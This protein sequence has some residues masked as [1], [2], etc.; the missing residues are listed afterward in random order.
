MPGFIKSSTGAIAEAAKKILLDLG[1]PQ[2]ATALLARV[3]DDTLPLVSRVHAMKTLGGL[4]KNAPANLTEM[5]RTFRKQK[6]LPP[7]LRAAALEVLMEKTPGE[8]VNLVRDTMVNGE[9][10]EKQKGMALLGKFKN[11]DAKK[12]T[13]EHG[14]MLVRDTLDPAVQVEIIEIAHQQDKKRGE[15]RKV[16]DQWQAHLDL[17]EKPLSV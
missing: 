12:Y 16:L 4:G 10:I 9:S 11:D 1:K 17:T 2:D 7:A 13:F 3:K 15:W 5:C 14:V 8:A 6:E